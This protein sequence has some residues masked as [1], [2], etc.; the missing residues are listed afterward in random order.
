V[1]KKV[2]FYFGTPK[3]VTYRDQMAF[4]STRLV[5]TYVVLILIVFILL[6]EIKPVCSG[7]LPMVKLKL[8]CPISYRRRLPSNN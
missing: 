5:S 4:L 1:I 6:V 3:R 7:R 8:L 2:G